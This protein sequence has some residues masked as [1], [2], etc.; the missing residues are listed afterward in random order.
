MGACI[1]NRIKAVTPHTGSFRFVPFC[2]RY[3]IFCF[4]KKKKLF[5]GA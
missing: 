5:F 1:S 3:G 4:K 2:S